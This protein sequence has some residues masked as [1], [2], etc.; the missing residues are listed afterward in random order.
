M[1]SVMDGREQEGGGYLSVEISEAGG[2][3][4]ELAE[5]TMLCGGRRI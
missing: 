2:T 4:L 3:L 1:V 5:V